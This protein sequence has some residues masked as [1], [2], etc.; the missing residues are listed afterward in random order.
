MMCIYRLLDRNGCVVLPAILKHSRYKSGKTITKVGIPFLTLPFQRNRFL[1]RLQQQYIIMWGQPQENISN[2]VQD[3]PTIAARPPR[4]ESKYGR[5]VAPTASTIGLQGTTRVPG[6]N[7]GLGTAQSLTVKKERSLGPA[8]PHR[9]NAR[10]FL[11]KGGKD[12]VSNEMP[13]QFVRPLVRPKKPTIPNRSEK[14]V[15]GLQTTKNFL[16]A[17]AVEN[18]LAGKFSII[19]YAYVYI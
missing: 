13:P 11:R 10:D 7:T 12:V 15:M 8:A 9:S 17:N 16:V 4:Y 14:P 18:I 5:G 1:F 19:M 6:A 3:E 2:W